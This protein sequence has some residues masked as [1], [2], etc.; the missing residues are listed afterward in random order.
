MSDMSLGAAPPSERVTFIVPIYNRLEFLP[1]CLESLRDQTAAD[2]EAIIVDDASTSGDVKA[3]VDAFGDDRFRVL[4]HSRNRGL[5]ASRNT[6][7]GA[8]ATR[9]VLCVDADDKLPPDALETLLALARRHPEGDVFFGHLYTFGVTNRLLP[10]AAQTPR[11]FFTKRYM[12]GAGFLL[13]REFWEKVGGYCE[14][15]IF[16]AGQEDADFWVAALEHG[17]RPFHIDKVAYLYRRHGGSMT[18]QIHP[19][20]GKVR[21]HIYRRHKKYIN[22]V[23]MRRRYW[24]NSYWRASIGHRQRGETRYANLFTLWAFFIGREQMD[25][26]RLAAVAKTLSFKD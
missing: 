4:R 5:A 16:R 13:R 22:S 25:L 3:A 17:V 24:A 18:S 9:W 8:A 14:D 12:P 2:W 11:Q 6:A 19:D 23:G 15:E 7:I 20:Y 10:Q 1:D 26:D 21:K